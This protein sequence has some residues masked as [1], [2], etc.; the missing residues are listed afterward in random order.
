MVMAFFNQISTQS[1]CA[2]EVNTNNERTHTR[3][4]V[5]SRAKRTNSC[6]YSY[7]RSNTTAM[8]TIVD[9]SG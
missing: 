7:M 3:A 6:A 2:R 1:L 4:E 5:G 8:L 9:Y